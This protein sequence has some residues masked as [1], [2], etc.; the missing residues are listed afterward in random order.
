MQI[1]FADAVLGL[2]GCRPAPLDLIEDIESI[3][4]EIIDT[5]DAAEL[6]PAEPALL[7][8]KMENRVPR[9]HLEAPAV[10][11]SDELRKLRYKS[12]ASP[13]SAVMAAI[14]LPKNRLARWRNR[15]LT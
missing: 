5:L 6:P 13:M 7:L 4:D 11:S 10:S 9:H 1:P 12:V 14:Q 3:G 15:D 2:F 8:Q